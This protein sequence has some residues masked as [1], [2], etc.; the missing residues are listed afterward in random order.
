MRRLMRTSRKR[1]AL[2]VV[3]MAAV[4]VVGGASG[5]PTVTIGQTD[6]EA[7]IGSGTA[8]WFVQMG[9]A[10]GT[11]FVVPPGNWN[12]TGWK[13]YAIGSGP[14]SMSMMI[15]R[16]AG[17]G[18]Y[19]VVG[20]SEVES[21]TPGSLNSFAD[22]NFAVQGGDRLGLYDPNGTAIVASA[23]GAGGDALSFGIS[24]T[25]PAWVRSSHPS[26]PRTTA[27]A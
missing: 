3:G 8:A 17:L 22:V 2:L 23:T 18:H 12:I 11:E 5:S 21:L 10:S 20:A 14:Q 13:T 24:D 25:R 1:L 26:A 19:T 6:P 15:F 27:S 4:L 16:P 9:D 7:A